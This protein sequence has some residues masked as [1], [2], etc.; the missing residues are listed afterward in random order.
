M[1]KEVNEM[2]EYEDF[3][4]DIVSLE[5]EQGNVQ[6]FTY[7]ETVIYGGTPY[8]VLQPEDSDGVVI[9]EV[10]NIA[11]EKESYDAVTDDSLCEKI[12]ERFKSEFGEKY[13]FA[14]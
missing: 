6:D 14:D 10:R 1:V 11:T 2:E 8:A 13:D 9:V 7:L 3:S 4:G 5:D 12:F